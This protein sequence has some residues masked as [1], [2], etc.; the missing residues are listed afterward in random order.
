MRML[1][2]VLAV[3]ADAVSL[4]RI[5]NGTTRHKSGK[6]GKGREEKRESC[7]LT[8]LHRQKVCRLPD[9]LSGG[10][11]RR[12][13]WL[14]FP[15]DGNSLGRAH[16]SAQHNTHK[17]DAKVEHTDQKRKHGAAAASEHRPDCSTIARE[18][19]QFRLAT[20]FPL[21]GQHNPECASGGAHSTACVEQNGLQ[22]QAL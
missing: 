22:A 6:R 19:C 20:R 8:W 4:T 12:R 21:R 5:T 3:L 18:V 13:S 14:T 16:A 17:T 2:E 7:T 10:S 9:H 1:K 11:G 15:A